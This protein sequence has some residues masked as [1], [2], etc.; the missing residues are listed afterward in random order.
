[1]AGTPAHVVLVGPP[2][3]Q[4]VL[5]ASVLSLLLLLWPTDPLLFAAVRPPALSEA[6]ATSHGVGR[7]WLAERHERGGSSSQA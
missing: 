3:A 5:H 4:R 6:T 2:G 1:M 7:P